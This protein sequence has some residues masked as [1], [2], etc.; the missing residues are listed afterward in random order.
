MINMVDMMTI[1]VTGSDVERMNPSTPS[2]A[3]FALHNGWAVVV[4]VAA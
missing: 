1:G 2:A 3:G 4:S